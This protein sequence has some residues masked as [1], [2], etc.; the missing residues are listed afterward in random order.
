M[1]YKKLVNENMF[2]WSK[3]I[4][5]IFLTENTKSIRIG[6]FAEQ[7]LTDMQVKC[8]LSPIKQIRKERKK[9]EDKYKL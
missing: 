8:K 3:N 9:E 7:T 2:Y 4:V 1:N 6:N 5:N